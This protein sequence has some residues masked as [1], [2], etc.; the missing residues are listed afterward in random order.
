MGSRSP[1]LRRHRKSLEAYGLPLKV[2]H[3]RCLF[4]PLATLYDLDELEKARGFLIGTTNILIPQYPKFKADVV[5][6]LDT[7]KM[8]FL[9]ERLGKIVKVHSQDEKKMMQTL[10]VQVVPKGSDETFGWGVGEEA[11]VMQSFEKGEVA[12]RNTFHEYIQG[13]L[14]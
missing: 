2:F 13:L 9:N 7:E 12:V 1:Q 5:L 3:K 14:R 10:L 11:G 4:L 6:N 8:E